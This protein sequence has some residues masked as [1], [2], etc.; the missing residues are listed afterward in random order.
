MKTYLRILTYAKPYGKYLPRYI[1][2]AT[3][4]IIFGLLNYA[5]LKPLFD[6][7]FEQVD[8][9]QIAQYKEPIEFS[10]S[11]DYFM[12]TFNHFLVKAS[13]TQGKM[14]TL[15]YVCAVIVFSV[16]LA[17]VF[18]YVSNVL[19]AKIRAKVIEK[20]RMDIFDKASELH[21][22]YFTNE[23]K[24]DLMSRITNDVQEVENTIVS[25]LK[26]AFREPATILITFVL[27]FAISAK[28]TFFTILFL[29]VTGYLISAITVRLK[30]KATQSQESLGRIVNILEETL[31]GIRVIKAFSA[32]NYI[33]QVFGREVAEYS[34][35]NISMARK[36]ELAPP[37]SQFLGVVVVAGILLYGGNLV[38]NQES[39]LSASAFFTYIILFTQVLNP[40]KAISQAISNIQRGIASGDRIFAIIDTPPAITDPEPAKVMNDF[41]QGIEF[42]DVWFSYDKEWVL[43][44]LNLR[45]EKGK[46]VALV[47]PSGG[48]KSTI[49]DLVPRFY[50]PTKGAVWIDGEDIRSY[51]IAD[52]RKHMGIVTQESILFNDSVFKNIAFGKPD[53]NKEDVI[54]AAKIANAHAFIEQL[55]N[56]YDTMIGER[57][58]RL[59][60][61]QRQRLSIARA[62]FKNPSIL[63]LDEA[64]S[65]LDSESEKLVQDALF[66]LMKNRTSLV[67]A[68]RLST[69]QHADEIIVVEKGEIIERGSHSE[70]IERDGLYKKLS[71]IQQS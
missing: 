33:S 27:L 46:S 32:R 42:K 8:I 66:N 62:V 16:L 22:G 53:A 34:G 1:F 54:K 61:G 68:H 4:A 23:R 44:G 64:T 6:V 3:L 31:S 56:G 65:A 18:T 48:G 39:D 50:D 67:I 28:L 69:I 63:I 13:E 55:E 21:L 25:T 59:S 12:H 38:L 57:G 71:Q 14:G 15:K 58:T 19:L 52:L 40:S 43:K 24:G 10:L 70:L 35:I 49:A 37:L 17:N 45:I 9:E 5:L 7:V 36:N 29:P 60:G 2:F 41:E 30:K 11:L 47:G 26:V 51:K 20:L